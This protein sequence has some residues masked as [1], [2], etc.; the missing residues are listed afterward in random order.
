ML[1]DCKAEQSNAGMLKHLSGLL[2]G[3][4]FTVTLTASFMAALPCTDSP[5]QS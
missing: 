2:A 1:S 5:F 3:A 4:S